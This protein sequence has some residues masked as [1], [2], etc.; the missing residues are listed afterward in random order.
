MDKSVII[1][2]SFYD[3]SAKILFDS[4]G[5]LIHIWGQMMIYKHNGSIGL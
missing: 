5:H 3:R 1:L 2:P 4:F